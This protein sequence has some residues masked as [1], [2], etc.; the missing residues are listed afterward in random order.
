MAGEFGART[1]HGDLVVA[2][3]L[4]HKMMRLL[5]QPMKKV[6]PPIISFGSLAWRVKFYE[7]RDRE[8]KRKSEWV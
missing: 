1:N 5:A 3:A 2:D 4:C 8:L 6:E 7:E